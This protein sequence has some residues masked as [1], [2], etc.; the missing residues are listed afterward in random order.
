MDTKR[1]FKLN[2]HHLQG[3]VAMLLVVVIIF[4]S[5]YLSGFGGFLFGT[6][7]RS[8]PDAVEMTMYAS[9]GMVEARVDFQEII[10]LSGLPG[11][12]LGRIGPEH[13][14]LGGYF[15]GL[16]VGSVEASGSELVI[17]ILPYSD[18]NNQG[19][20]DWED[21]AGTDGLIAITPEVF[22]D[23]SYFYQAVV[24]VIYP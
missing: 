2:K 10:T 1:K 22:S 7:F 15:Y 13:I 16:S 18:A 11:D 4:S 8:N 14:Y 5:F 3:A 23:Q 19:D 12:D 17:S 21:Y 9:P 24:S 6:M 20:V